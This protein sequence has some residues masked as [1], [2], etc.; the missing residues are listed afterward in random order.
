MEKKHNKKDALSAVIYTVIVLAVSNILWYFGY[1]NQESDYAMSFVILAQF[2][3]MILCLIMS[4]ITGEGWDNLGIT[5]HRKSWKYLLL[6]I[7]GSVI[8]TYAADPLMLMLFPENVSTTF[9]ADKISQVL[10]MALLGTACFIECLGEELGWIGYLYGKLEKLFGTKPA[11]IFI[12][13]I[14]GLYH[15]GI[16]VIMDYPIQGLIE[17]IISNICL[18]FFMV[19]LYKR[20]ESI[21]VCSIS[22]GICNLLPIFLTYE[23]DWYYT[24]LS[25]MAVTMIPSLIYAVFFG[26]KLSNKSITPP[27]PAGHQN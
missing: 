13:I 11:C 18:S 27:Q 6:S 21:F 1:T 19:Y 15:I 23:N 10:L 16:L 5:I 9:L 8:V 2:F 22:H 26:W 3:P 24:H 20:S 12:G 4:K 14:R 25:A 7:I 17:I